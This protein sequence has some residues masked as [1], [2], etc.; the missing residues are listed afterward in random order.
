MLTNEELDALYQ[1]VVEKV[2]PVDMTDLGM[3][4]TL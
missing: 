1:Q 2:W 3:I 4:I